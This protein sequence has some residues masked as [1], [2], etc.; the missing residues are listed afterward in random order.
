MKFIEYNYN[1]KKKRTGDCVIRAIALATNS[2]WEYIYRE[3]TEYGIKKGLMLNDCKN[4]K[5]YLKRI[6]YELQKMPRRKDRTRYTLE[7]FCNEI[8]KE[9][10]IYIVK[11]ARHLT[12]VKNRAVID[13]WDCSNRY[14][15]NYWKFRKE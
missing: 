10:N 1:P 12:V 9:E 11:L 2:S 7:E 6:G 3:L 14:V 8:A 15:G 13:T 5:A 4:W